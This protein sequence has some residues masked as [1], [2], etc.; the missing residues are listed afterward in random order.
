VDLARQVLGEIDLDPAT[1]P[2]AQETVKAAKFY[3]PQD[4]G[5]AHEWHG[6]VWL[7]PPFGQPEIAHFVDKLIAERRAGRVTA[8]IMLTHNYTDTDWFHASVALTDAIGF[9]YKRV[10]FYDPDGFIASPTQGQAFHYFGPDVNAFCSAFS[11]I[12]FIVIPWNP[13]RAT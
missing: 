6:R 8:A 10:K 9:T 5:L 11:K 2:I 7:N 3:T 13:G 4:N 12:G 1:Q